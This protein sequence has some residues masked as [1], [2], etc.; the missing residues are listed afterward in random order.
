MIMGG[1]FLA[2]LTRPSAVF[3]IPAIISMEVLH[4]KDIKTFLKNTVSY[5][6]P[7]L[8]S[9]LLVFFIQYQATGVWF[10]FF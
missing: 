2:S 1:L 3:F 5:I 8:M 10:A 7:S 4:Y 9:I 6:T